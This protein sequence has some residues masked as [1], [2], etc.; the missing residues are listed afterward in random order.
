MEMAA[1]FARLT[2]RLR[3]KGQAALGGEIVTGLLHL[4]LRPF[5]PAHRL[6]ILPTG[7]R[8]VLLQHGGRG[9]VSG[10]GWVLELQPGPVC[11]SSGGVGGELCRLPLLIGPTII[12]RRGRPFCWRAVPLASIALAIRRRLRLLTVLRLGGIGSMVH[13]L[14]LLHLRPAING[15]FAIRRGLFALR[16]FE[17]QP[18]PALHRAGRTL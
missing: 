10:G 4:L 17:L 12:P 2:I 7:R 18:S 3:L 16:I 11:F 5:H 1:G 8:G 6:L 13:D 9:T 15:D 14:L